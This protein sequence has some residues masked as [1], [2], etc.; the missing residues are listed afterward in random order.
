MTGDKTREEGRK[1]LS[2]RSKAAGFEPRKS[3]ATDTISEGSGE[4]V[5]EEVNAEADEVLEDDFT[6]E[7]DNSNPS[8]RERLGPLIEPAIQTVDAIRVEKQRIGVGEINKISPTGID[9]DIWQQVY[10]DVKLSRDQIMIEESLVAR[11]IAGERVI[12]VVKPTYNINTNQ[13]T[14]SRVCEP[15]ATQEAVLAVEN[16]QTVGVTQRYDFIRNKQKTDLNHIN[17][18][19]RITEPKRNKSH[20]TLIEELFEFDPIK[21]AG[22]EELPIG[23]RRPQVIIHE[24]QAD[25]TESFEF[26]CRFLRD[27]YSTIEGGEP[28][29]EPVEFVTNSPRIPSLSDRV[30]RLD[31]TGDEWE[32]TSESDA[33][34]ARRNGTD[35]LPKLTEIVKTQFSGNLGF[36]IINVSSSAGASLFGESQIGEELYQ[37]F[38]DGL[39]CDGESHRTV[40][41][42]SPR[43]V[44]D[45]NWGARFA[46]YLG[47]EGVDES[48]SVV[49]VEDGYWDAV[50]QTGWRA[51]ALTERQDTGEESDQHYLYKATLA[52]AVGTK[53]FN[54][55]LISEKDE[56]FNEYTLECVQT[57]E[58]TGNAIPDITV[59]L[60]QHSSFEQSLQTLVSDEIPWSEFRKAA[61]EIETAKQE[62]AFKF[63]KIRETLDKIESDEINFI[64]IVVPP[65]IVEIDRNGG[66]IITNLVSHWNQTN[67]QMTAKLLTL[68]FST[69]G[70]TKLN[71]V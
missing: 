30:L 49:G 9:T 3:S 1:S 40:I 14:I 45:T 61:F 36:L 2:D 63:R 68:Q 15:T 67:D 21:G 44:R 35:I 37:Y 29:V 10:P 71:V 31:M 39:Q 47:F 38:I 56:F 41:T 17:M 46:D 54:S 7:G 59:D 65:W 42:T 57:E 16:P 26:L 66:N 62:G 4:N 52:H 60:T 23:R 58:P 18:T 32:I 8:V 51:I 70:R 33:V 25:E 50:E 20:S 5:A 48:A 6:Q 22:S 55:A 12:Q 69:G 24:Q 28:S 27:Y 11:G 19:E 43:N 64:G 34:H 13:E 53:A